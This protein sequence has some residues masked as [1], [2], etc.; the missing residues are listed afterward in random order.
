ML[1]SKIVLLHDTLCLV[2]NGGSDFLF[3]SSQTADVSYQTEKK[4]ESDEAAQYDPLLLSGT[5]D[6]Y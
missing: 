5:N 6:Y 2:T 3:V 1:T 4:K